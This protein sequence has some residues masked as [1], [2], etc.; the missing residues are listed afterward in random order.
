MPF[1][2]LSQPILSTFDSIPIQKSVDEDI[3]FAI[4]HPVIKTATLKLFKPHKE[5]NKISHIMD[6]IGETMFAKIFGNWRSWQDMNFRIP[7]TLDLNRKDFNWK[8][9]L[10][11]FGN[12]ERDLQKKQVFTNK[13]ILIRN[14]IARVDWNSDSWCIVQ[15]EG[16][17]IGGLTI[18]SNPF[19]DSIFLKSAS[20]VPGY[21][22]ETKQIQPSQPFDLVKY[23]KMLGAPEYGAIGTLHD[24]QVIILYY[25]IQKKIW[26]FQEGE[27]I[28]RFLMESV[29]VEILQENGKNRYIAHHRQPELKIQ[30]NKRPEK[31]AEI[32]RLA[33]FGR[34]LAWA[35]SNAEF[36]F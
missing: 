13:K 27:P 29:S 12:L 9:D 26:I 25:A 17:I 20:F 1:T 6:E 16:K 30:A 10:Y 36:N 23:A 24:K 21:Q 22:L 8:V 19:T 32:I 31:Q 34:L 33:L 14:K 2:S 18:R 15:E 7:C 35:V 11:A 5:K 28:A 4:V 3:H